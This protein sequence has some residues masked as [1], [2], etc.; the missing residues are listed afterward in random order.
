VELGEGFG[1]KLREYFAGSGIVPVQ[2]LSRKKNEITSLVRVPSAAG[3]I[4]CYCKAKQKRVASEAD[5]A[6]ALLEA[7]QKKLLLLYVA[8]GTLS[9]RAAAVAAEQGFVAVQPWA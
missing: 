2:L 9:K 3:E 7:Q 8:G 4:L 5:L 6:L 1:E